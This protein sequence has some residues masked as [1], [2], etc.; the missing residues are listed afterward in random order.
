MKF[1]EP[2]CRSCTCFLY[3]AGTTNR[4]AP[5]HFLV[6][7]IEQAWAELMNEDRAAGRPKWRPHVKEEVAA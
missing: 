7:A 1:D 6:V 3:R 4:S 5:W 2:H